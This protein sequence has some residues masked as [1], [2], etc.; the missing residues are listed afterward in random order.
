MNAGGKLALLSESTN[1][2]VRHRTSPHLCF[3][4]SN[5]GKD[6]ENVY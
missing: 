4:G 6:L 5:R 2:E 1:T 3:K